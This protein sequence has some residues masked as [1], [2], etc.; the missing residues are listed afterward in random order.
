MSDESTARSLIPPPDESVAPLARELIAGGA[1]VALVGLNRAVLQD[2]A[3]LAPERCAV[4]TPDVSDGAAMAAM[5]VDWMSRHGVPDLV[6]ANA[7]VA[8]GFDTARPED[9]AVLRRMVPVADAEDALQEAWLRAAGALAR[10]DGR[11]RL[12]TWLVGIAINCARERLRARAGTSAVD[13]DELVLP[14]PSGDLRVDLERALL[15]LPEGFRA[16]VVLHD[17]WGHDH[18]EIAHML[19]IEEAT[20]RSQL[21]RSV[22]GISQAA[23]NSASTRC[24][25]TCPLISLS[26]PFLGGRIAWIAEWLR[27]SRDQAAATS[28][29]CQPPPASRPSR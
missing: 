14:P 24:Q 21:A 17:V 27:E 2:L 5:G 4:Y 10:F 16:V 8:G 22:I 18:A 20:S 1:H 23:S 11:S 19:G 13:P 9:L 6:I 7:G 29:N 26:P 25:S 3:A 28:R 15:A 12:R